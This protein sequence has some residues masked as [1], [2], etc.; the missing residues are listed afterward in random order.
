MGWTNPVDE[1]LI[2]FEGG[3]QVD[4]SVRGVLKDFNFESLHHKI[5]P[6][7]IRYGNAGSLLSIKYDQDPS[8]IIGLIDKTWKQF[9]PDEPLEYSFL[10][11]NLDH[12]YASEFRLQSLILIFTLMSIGIAS[13]GLYGFSA[14]TSGR[15]AREI[16]IRKILGASDQGIFTMLTMEYI[17]YVLMAFILAAIPSL[18]V[19]RA[20]LRN[21]AYRIDLDP[22]TFLTGGLIALLITLLTVGFQSMK[23]AVV[24][25]VNSIKHE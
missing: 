25:P 23:L 5:R 15:R 17:K 14:Y 6:L 12:Q 18:F 9:A 24:S 1:K 22:W 3:K 20:W 16:G 2:T 8:L 10:D 21:F 11:E 4:L 13:L 7:L 19:M